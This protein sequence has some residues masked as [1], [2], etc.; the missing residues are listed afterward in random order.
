[1]NG[2][3][4]R[5]FPAERTAWQR[6]R[7]LEQ[8][9]FQAQP[10]IERGW[11]LERSQAKECSGEGEE[12]MG[13]ERRPDDQGLYRPCYGIQIVFGAYVV[14]LDGP[15]FM[16]QMFGFE[17]SRCR[18]RDRVSKAGAFIRKWSH[19]E[20]RHC[21]WFGCMSSISKVYTVPG[22]CC[23][24]LRSWAWWE[25]LKPMETRT[26]KSHSFRFCL[27]HWDYAAKLSW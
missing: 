13:R 25:V 18:V 7:K 20:S 24:S 26:V 16:A 12:E 5:L 1:M 27:A 19:E 8:P 11:W 15:S 17:F 6:T 10:I 9:V 3:G 14:L 4:W 21:V 2:W 22:R 23:G